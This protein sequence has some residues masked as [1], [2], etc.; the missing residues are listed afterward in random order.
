M[1]SSAARHGDPRYHADDIAKLKA[2]NAALRAENQRLR[3]GLTGRCDSVRGSL[4][5][6]GT[7]GH[8]SPH[9][10]PTTGHRAMRWGMSG[11][12]CFDPDC[13][14]TPGHQ[15]PHNDGKG[16]SWWPMTDDEYD[17]LDVPA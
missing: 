14:K 11:E 13:V 15:A 3:I 10:A 5:C 4:R 6:V 7:T 8:A 2:E 17:A 12:G 9:W 16:R 1:K